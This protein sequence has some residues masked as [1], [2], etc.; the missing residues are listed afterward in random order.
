VARAPRWALAGVWTAMISSII[1]TQ[2][3]GNAFIYFQF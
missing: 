3:N 2:E 1:L